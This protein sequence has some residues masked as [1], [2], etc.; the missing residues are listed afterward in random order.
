M[1]LFCGKI[2]N[3]NSSIYKGCVVAFV[4]LSCGLG[5][6]QLTISTIITWTA[7]KDE[8]ILNIVIAILINVGGF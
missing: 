3:L 2:L 1:Q 6:F 8:L 5:L 4:S 7:K